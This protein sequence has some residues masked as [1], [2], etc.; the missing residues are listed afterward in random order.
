MLEG[1]VAIHNAS[2]FAAAGVDHRQLRDWVA[3]LRR[4]LRRTWRVPGV[5]ICVESPKGVRSKVRMRILFSQGAVDWYQ[6]GG[7]LKQ[8]AEGTLS[9]AF[10]PEATADLDNRS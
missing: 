8:F 1:R 10:E 5:Q 9:F 3:H 2:E 4:S 7:K 6:R